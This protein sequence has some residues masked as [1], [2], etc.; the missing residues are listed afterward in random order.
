MIEHRPIAGFG[1]GK[2]TFNEDKKDYY[3][4]WAG[5]SSEFA[6]Y[7]NNPHND[8]LNVL[9][10]MGVIGLIPHLALLWTAWQLL[11]RSHIRWRST[12]PFGAEL[13]KFGQALF[14]VLLIAAQ[15]HPVMYMSFAQVLFYFLLGIVASEAR[16]IEVGRQP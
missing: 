1:F 3:A 2:S 4:S 11:W 15:F 6:V 5:V 7:P 14:V 16:S 9:V 12:N 13:S 10:N 8:F